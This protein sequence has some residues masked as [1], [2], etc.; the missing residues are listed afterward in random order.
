MKRIFAILTACLAANAFAA[1]TLN[2]AEGWLESGFVEW[3]HLSG[4]TGYNVYYQAD[5]SSSWIKLDNEL[6]R[7]YG[8]YGRADVVGIA[9]GNYLMKV[10]PVGASGEMTAEAATTPNLTVKAYNREGY[11]HFGYTDGVG[12]Y[13][14]DGTLKDNAR[15]LYITAENAKT[16]TL[17]IIEK[18]GKAAVSHTGLQ[19]IITAYEKGAETRPL[20]IRIIGTVEA[21]DMDAFGSKEE[22]LQIKGKNNTIPMHITLE[23]IGNDACIRGFG[24]LMRNAVS[25]ELRNFAIMLCMDDC[26]SI[27]TKNLRIWVHNLDLFYGQAGSA[28]DQVKGDGTVDLKGDSQFITIS[29]NHFWDS[30]K[31]S[32]C[33]MKSETG[34]NWIT[35]HHNWFDHSDSRHPRVRTMSVHVWNNYF[36]GNAK[37]GV[38]VTTGACAFVDRNYFRNAHDPMMSSLCGTDATGDG[39]F[40]KENA[41][42]IKAY[43]NVFAEKNT[44]GVKFQYIPW[45]E[46]LSSFDSYEVADPAE[47]VPENVVEVYT[48][49]DGTKATAAYS[50]FDTDSKL[51]YSYHP[52]AADDVPSVVTGAFG[53]GRMQHGDFSWSFDNTREDANYAVISALKTAI[54]NYTS[55]FLG[56][57]WSKAVGLTKVTSDTGMGQKY[58]LQGRKTGNEKGFVIRDGKKHIYK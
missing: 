36:D 27:D 20:A 26:V 42:F 12:A 11:A 32:L 50:N 52:D 3:S 58:D 34:P 19:N 23:G 24:L 55:S 31:S 45:R 17:D 29:F 43:G 54:T 35:Y 41:G 49:K 30:G 15:V 39:T 16:V 37:Y 46:G 57:D 10:V 8:T 4:A 5:G 22:G 2:K 48:Q 47:Q 21:A 6:V 51:M 13:K 53:A 14:D 7:C 28:S 38:G 33:G 1:V 25:V 40:S 9:A 44:N 56:Y 18:A